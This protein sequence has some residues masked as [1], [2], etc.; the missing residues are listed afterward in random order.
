MA[1]MPRRS[2]VFFFIL[3]GRTGCATH[4]PEDEYS[5]CDFYALTTLGDGAISPLPVS[6]E[7]HH[8]V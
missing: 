1:F 3:L 7:I 8:K 2:N 6:L 5:T 4:F